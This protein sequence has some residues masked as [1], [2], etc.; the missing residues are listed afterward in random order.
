MF[1]PCGHATARRMK[2]EVETPRN[3]VLLL[4]LLAYI[5]NFID[6]NILGVLAVPIR[7]D[8]GLS[9]TALGSLGV[10]F[11]LFYAVAAVPIGWIADRKGRVGIIA[12]AVTVWSLFTAA[13]GMVQT[14][15]QL[16]VARMGV[17][18]GEAGGVAPSYALIS[19]Y[20]PKSQRARALAAFSFGIPI[21]SA[22]GIFFGGWIA[23]HFSWRAAFLIVGLAGLPV[24]IL[25]RS[26][27]AE[28]S[29][30]DAV[31][32]T[33]KEPLL[34]ARTLLAIPSFW[35]LSLGAAAGSIP[36]Y[37]FIFWLPSFF[38]RSFALPIEQVGWFYGSIVLV[39]GL[40]GTWLG[41]WVGDRAGPQ[42]PGIYAL[43][44]AACFLIA[45][46]LFAIGLFAE[47]L[48][49]AWIVF[50]L[51]QMLT[52]AWLGPVVSAIQQIVEPPLRATASAS[53]L[54]IN[55]LI[56]IAGG[57]YALGW[58]SD[59]LKAAHGADSLRYSILYALA[60][61]ALSAAIYLAAAAKLPA[62]IRM[63]DSAN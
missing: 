36:G 24:A 28:P 48:V 33:V 32:A 41:G 49:A 8:F 17:A 20:F 13:C 62:D 54:F 30:P 40:A 21:G 22:L 25:I 10:A 57:I 53:F 6:R 63:N 7:A 39:G 56:G 11:G 61:Y 46:P 35:L 14:Y 9:D 12:A 23:G 31:P 47:S 44:P 37:G 5:F 38:N 2:A 58:M 1:D 3:R 55:N 29:R 16:I 15:A 59:A 26:M 42:R 45:I 50:A 60:F 19:D 52:L 43:I 18:V 27:I 4:L 51:A 34:A